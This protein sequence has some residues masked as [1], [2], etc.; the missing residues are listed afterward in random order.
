MVVGDDR[1]RFTVKEVP[2]MSHSPH[3]S[4]NLSFVAQI[5]V[6][7]L[8]VTTG[9]IGYNVLM[10]VVVISLKTAPSSVFA[11]SVWILKGRSKLAALRMDDPVSA[12]FRLSDACCRAGVHTYGVLA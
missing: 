2:K 12:L 8:V 4:E 6:L 5:I 1:E 7:C 9:G 10:F 3:E 11:Q